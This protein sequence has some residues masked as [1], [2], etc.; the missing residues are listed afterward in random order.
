MRGGTVA[1]IIVGVALIRLTSG[2]S[3]GSKAIQ[4][5][6][7]VIVSARSV[8]QLGYVVRGIEL[9]LKVSERVHAFCML[10]SC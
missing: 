2:M 8:S 10:Q 1:H 5:V 4:R 7:S 3:S 9:I 6:V